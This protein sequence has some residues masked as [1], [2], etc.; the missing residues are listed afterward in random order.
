MKKE[1][2]GTVEKRKKFSRK[3]WKIMKLCGIFC[4][5]LSLNLSA[6]VYSQQNKVSLDLKEVTLE[7]FIEAVKQQT[8]VNFLYNASLFEGAEKVSVKAK[9]EPLSKVLEEILGQKGYA[10][11]YRDE[12]VVILK[13][14]PQPFV[15]QVNKR[16]VSGTVRDADGEPVP[17]VSVLVKGT[18]VGVAT[19]VNGRFELRVDDNPEV[20]LQFSFVGM[21]SQEVKIGTHTTL[22]VVLESDT[23]ALDEVLVTGYQTISKERATGSFDM[24]SREQLNKPASTLASRLVGVTAGVQNNLDED[25]NIVFEIRGQTS[26]NT[27]NARPLIVVD[28][29]PVE[30]EFSSINPNDVESVTILKD[31]AAASIWGARSANGVIVVTTKK[32]ALSAQKG[33]KIEVSAF[34]EVQ[35]KIDLDQYNPLASSAETVEYERKGFET[36]FFGIGVP[37]DDSWM[38]AQAAY[39]QVT[40]ALNENRLGHL[41]D[42]DLEATLEKLSRQNNKE[43]IK[44][45]LLQI[46]VT[47]QYNVNISGANERMNNMLSLMY[48]RE[49]DGFKENHKDK[50]MVNYRTNVNLFKW[51]DFNFS[52]MVQYNKV[53]NSGINATSLPRYA[54]DFFSIAYGSIQG[55]QPYDMLVDEDGNRTK[56]SG[57]FY[58]QMLDRNVPTENFPYSDW[59]YNPITEI[60]N[61]DLGYKELNARIQG[62]LTVHLLEG[63]DFD[64][65]IQYEMYN[66]FYTDIYNENTFTVRRL[67]NTTSSWDKTTNVVTPNLAKGGFKEESKE[68]IT[69]Y[70]FRNQLNFDRV[71]KDRHALNVILGTEIRERIAKTTDYPRTYGYSDETLSVGIYP[72]GPTGTLDWTGFPNGMMDNAF[73]YTNSYTY[74]RDRYFSLYANAAYTLDEKYT[75]SGSVRTDASNLITDDP[76]YRYAP[77]WSVGLGWQIGKEDFMQDAKWI[78]RLNIRATYGYNG[79]VDKSTSF[80]PLISVNSTQNEYT[81]GFTAAIQS[82]GNPDLRWERTG[83]WDVGID[84]SFLGGKLAGKIDVYSKLGKDLM[85]SM[86][87]PSV[88][89]TTSQSLNAA[90]MTNRGIELEVGTQLPIYGDKIVWTG[91]LNFSYNKNKIQELYKAT[92]RASELYS[93]GTYAYVEGYDANTLW[94]FEYAGVENRGTGASLD[95]QPVVKGVNGET[96]DFSTWTPGNGL[97]Y[98]KN[99]GTKVAPYAFGFSNSFKIYDFNLSFLITGKFGHKFMR[100]PFN[101]PSM[102]GG[103][104]QPNKYY[105]EVVNSDPSEQVPIP[106]DKSEPRYYFWD[107]FY[108]YLDYLVESAAHIRL[109]EVNLTY[110]MPKHWL[111]RIGINQL[112]IYAQ[113]NNLCSWFKNKYKEDPE[114]P[115]GSIPLQ[116]TYT[117]GLRFDF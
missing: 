114:H 64:T 31:A 32:G 24:L 96:Y 69:S 35:P 34:V 21:K 61:R 88:N 90:K 59:S 112:S 108:P 38:N 58:P 81:H 22:N 49:R 93:G 62:G 63:L 100:T 76:K 46:P 20:V 105:S 28:G 41:S 23:K 91:N 80:R 70:N 67:I 95:W 86:S 117:F 29:F 79:N 2:L 66:T 113:G 18:Q 89:G 36:N 54:G 110:N 45:Y 98:M 83:T 55:L 68:E 16:T 37:A 115:L 50:L 94:V 33:A 15:P 106:F 82:F 116:A 44:K 11:D 47:Q 57:G 84:Y 48:E 111:Q 10:I 78:D 1:P 104:G 77:F 27:A 103:S 14:E 85:A 99:A 73:K 25:G 75:V 30:G 87:I 101:Y 53:K 8:G 7:E 109:Q 13:Q 40:A 39:S 4:F 65:K 52:G 26:L 74:N 6:N 92:Y 17:G 43:Q 72:N 102:A 42:G 3:M 107:R 9:K 12:V 19:D 56:L 60:E 5:V 71:F 51:L 97:D